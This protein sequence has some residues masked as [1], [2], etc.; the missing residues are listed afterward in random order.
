MAD[1]SNLPLEIYSDIFGRL[2][3]N[4][5]FKCRSV[6]KRF[7]FII[8][9]LKLRNLVIAEDEFKFTLNR[10][11]FA[12]NEPID[13]L[14]TILCPSN[15]AESLKIESQLRKNLFSSIKQLYIHSNYLS[16]KSDDLGNCLNHFKRLEILEILNLEIN[17]ESKLILP[18]LKVL[19]WSVRGD[20]CVLDTPKLELVKIQFLNGMDNIEFLYP[21]KIKHAEFQE[22][23]NILKKFVNLEHLAI[24]HLEFI[25]ADFLQHHSKLKQIHFDSN[26]VVFFELKQQKERLKRK[27]LKIFF[28]GINFDELPQYSSA[29]NHSELYE[30]NIK[31]LA[32]AYER[33]RIANVLPFVEQINYNTFED[34]FKQLPKDLIERF[35]NL[36]LVKVTK[37]VEDLK[38]FQNF[39]KNTS[40][41]SSLKLNNS[42]LN[43]QFYSEQLPACCPSI[44]NLTIK[45]EN[46][47]EIDFDFLFKLDYLISL[48]TNKQ[49]SIEF[50]YDLFTKLKHFEQIWFSHLEDKVRIVTNESKLL[51]LY[52][53]EKETQFHCLDEMFKFMRDNLVQ[54]MDLD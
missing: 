52:I 3:I 36:E 54:K 5:I 41:F 31:L 33:K 51:R 30:K 20:I 8:D 49:L 37:K 50:V 47:E 7:K 42:S 2:P 12:T 44:T 45:D 32:E 25:E 46:I 23:R 29:F 13:T 24:K 26:D 28:L 14:H 9:N 21:E 43:A 17:S 22:K 15:P 48:I 27:D 53:N 6:S 11:W 10:K 34:N 16:F 38:K 40:N 4:D 39:L 35:V 1:I 18:N 19:N